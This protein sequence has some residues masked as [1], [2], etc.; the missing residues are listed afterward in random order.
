MSTTSKPRE[1]MTPEAFRRHDSPATPP[2][3][4]QQRGV[5]YAIAAVLLLLGAAAAYAALSREDRQYVPT[6]L[7]LHTVERGTLSV[8]VTDRGNLESA[9]NI[10]HVCEV[11]GGTGGGTTILW[12]IPEGTR[13][14]KGDL[15]VELDSS[16]LQD[17]EKTQRIAYE[18]ALSTLARAEA[19][20]ETAE[21][22]LREYEEGT[23]V[24]DKKTNEADL[25]VAQENLRRAQEN[26]RFTEQLYRKGF[27]NKLDLEA[28]EFGVRNQQLLVDK[29]QTALDVLIN[30]TKDKMLTELR[31]DLDAKKRILAAEQ[32]KAEQE[33]ARLDKI[34]GQL[35]KCKIYAK[36][37]GMVVYY[38]APGRWGR[39]EDQ[40]Q[41][42]AVVRERQ[43]IIILPDLEN[44]RVRMLVHESKIDWIHPGQ[45]TR[46]RVDAF[47]GEVLTGKVLRVATT[48]E[49]GNWFEQDK[50]NYP[51][52]V[53][54]DGTIDGLKPGMTAQTT[55]LVDR[56]TDVLTVPLQCVQTVGRKQ[57]CYVVK[58][59][60]S[61]E[62]RSVKLGHTNDYAS[63]VLDGLDGGDRVVQSPVESLGLTTETVAE[64]TPEAGFTDD[65][66][67]KT[68]A[69]DDGSTQKAEAASTATP[70]ASGSQPASG[71][72]AAPKD[73]RG[74]RGGMSLMDSDKDGDGKV[75]K[76]EA[77][78]QMRQWFD[79][80]DTNSDGFIDRAENAAMIR[81]MRQLQQQSQG[82][83]SGG[84]SGP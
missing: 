44:M 51:V 4:R 22:A 26:L 38:T 78:E 73:G 21:K 84:P 34:V 29:A 79:R 65:D 6:D 42:G 81:R 31:G 35:D 25:T 19:D 40:I 23:F 63:E 64:G 57:Y 76:D 15:L 55:V 80:I 53:S 67:T 83:P 48:P 36:G 52:T 45:P 9:Q 59:D 33:K 68:K 1:A 61:I 50:R 54:I 10:E 24:Q 18:N 7:V 20:V 72:S 58:A 62:K 74:R 32:T 13:V 82:G 16:N 69:A 49:Q 60:G 37:D 71:E 11:E 70:G 8:E 77:P 5:W 12:I 14:S 39:Q 46:I 30:V 17:S 56:L 27:V 28:A 47:A 43:K 2:R 3:R 41:E 75:S 66:A